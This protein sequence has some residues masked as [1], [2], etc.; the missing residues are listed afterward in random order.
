MIWELLFL[1]LVPLVVFALLDYKTSQKTALIGAVITS[2]FVLVGIYHL[3]KQ[4]DG[5]EVASAGLLIT[6]ALASMKMKKDIYFKLQPGIVGLI[7]GCGM[8]VVY[9]VSKQSYFHYFEKYRPVLHQ[10]M[11]SMLA[12]QGF[13]QNTSTQ[14]DAML[15]LTIANAI[16]LIPLV[17]GLLLFHAVI[18]LYTAKNCSTKTWLLTRAMQ[19]PI[20]VVGTLIVAKFKAL[21]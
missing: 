9:F 19:L 16:S 3:T 10:T 7:F 14:Q 11:S 5:V 8:L 13:M 18:M 2:C 21:G 4:I 6:L 20:V 17:S 12:G 15:D 1:G